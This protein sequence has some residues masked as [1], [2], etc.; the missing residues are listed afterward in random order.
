[1]LCWIE[2]IRESNIAIANKFAPTKPSQRRASQSVSQN[3]GLLAHL[4]YNSALFI[5]SVFLLGLFTGD[6]E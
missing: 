3:M 1:L 5:F 4:I 2:F 6:I